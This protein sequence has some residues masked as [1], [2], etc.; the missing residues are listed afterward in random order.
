MVEVEGILSSPRFIKALLVHREVHPERLSLRA[1]A[2]KMDYA[3]EDASRRRRELE[4]AGLITITLEEN[5]GRI[6]AALSKLTPE[7]LRC[8]EHALEMNAEAAKARRRKRDA[9]R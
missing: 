5:A 4:E 8:A 6:P 1:F 3:K 7:G 9:A 2:D